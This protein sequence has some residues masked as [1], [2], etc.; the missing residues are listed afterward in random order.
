[1]YINVHLVCSFLLSVHR[2]DTAV[3][4]GRESP[5]GRSVSSTSMTG[6]RDSPSSLG[7]GSNGS[8]PTTSRIG[9]TNSDKE[10]GSFIFSLCFDKKI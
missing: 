9:K 4:G 7:S 10:K 2:E 5:S 6:G 8:S 3:S 1:M